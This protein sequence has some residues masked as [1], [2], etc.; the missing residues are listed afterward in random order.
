MTLPTNRDTVTC[1][2]FADDRALVRGSRLDVALA[3][4]QALDHDP[5]TTVLV[6]DAVTSGAVELDLRGEIEDIERRYAPPTSAAPDSTSDPDPT[7]SLR[8]RGPGR[9]KLGVVGREVTLL[10][11][12]WQWLAEQPGSASVTLRKLVERA[13][14]EGARDDAV[15]RARESAYR[16]MSVMAGDREGFEEATRAL[17]AGQET[18][19]ETHSAS[20]PVDVREHARRLADEAFHPKEPDDA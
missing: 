7:E 8:P 10:P 12:H 9:P 17:F 18:A 11:R 16:F 13:R 3:A 20:W 5:T 14:K 4:R 6:F 2:A 15:R 19:F 1:I